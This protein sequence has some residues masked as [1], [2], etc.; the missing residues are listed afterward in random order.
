MKIVFLVFGCL[1]VAFAGIWLFTIPPESPLAVPKATIGGGLALVGIGWMVAAAACR[2]DPP[3]Q[4][5]AMP[6]WQPQPPQ[7]QP[8]MSGPGS[9]A[10]PYQPQ[11]YPQPPAQYGQ[12][13]R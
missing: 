12:G 10:T 13:G 5:T 7:P 2:T 1:T 6:A 11:S 3:K 4:L 9:P 8:P